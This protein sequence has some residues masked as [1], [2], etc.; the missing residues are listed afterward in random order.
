MIFFFSKAKVRSIL[1]K[2]ENNK[3]PDEKAAS[4][5]WDDNLVNNDSLIFNM[6][7]VRSTS[8]LFIVCASIYK[9]YK[10]LHLMLCKFL[11]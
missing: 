4:L 6:F 2:R 3:L 11:L 8:L 7:Q 5:E 1:P 10:I 9:I